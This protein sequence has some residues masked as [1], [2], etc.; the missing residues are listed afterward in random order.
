M[1]LGRQKEMRSLD[2]VANRP[3]R[4]HHRFAHMGAEQLLEHFSN[5]TAPNFFPGFR[6][7]T[8]AK[9][10]QQRFPVET[11][12]L[13][14]SARRICDDHRW[15]LL[16]YVEQYFGE[17]IQWRRDPIS[18]Y[19]SPLS[20]H[21]DVKL[22][23]NDGSDARVLWEL[24]RLGHLLTLGRAYAV[25]GDEKLATEFFKQVRSW[26]EQNP[27]AKGQTGTVPWKSRCGR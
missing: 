19:V 23:R 3:A 17:E 21:R 11:S 18:G 2:L 27:L 12:E 20:Y 25:S 14:C 13:I 6:D 26:S 4:L 24:N 1:S 15:S 7:Q 16:G 5:R 9:I 8:T 22:V 10:Q